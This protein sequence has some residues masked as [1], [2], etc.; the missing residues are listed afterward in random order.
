MRTILCLNPIGILIKRESCHLFASFLHGTGMCVVFCVGF[1]EILP[2]PVVALQFAGIWNWIRIRGTLSC[3]HWQVTA[4][5]LFECLFCCVYLSR[6]QEIQLSNDNQEHFGLPKPLLIHTRI[7]TSSTVTSSPYITP[8]KQ[9]VSVKGNRQ[10]WW[11]AV[12]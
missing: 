1:R 8:E 9:M 4:L 3:I 2:S 5:S 11:V 7:C 12:M 6:S 10:N